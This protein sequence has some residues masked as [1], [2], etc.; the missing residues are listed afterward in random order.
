MA[1]SCNEFKAT[2]SMVLKLY[3]GD[4]A[5]VSGVVILKEFKEVESENIKGHVPGPRFT[6]LIPVSYFHFYRQEGA[7]FRRDY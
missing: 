2:G 1:L 4:E 6:L 7:R 5:W 3:W